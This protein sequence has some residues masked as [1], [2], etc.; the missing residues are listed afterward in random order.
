MIHTPKQN[1]LLVVGHGTRHAE[2][3]R[4]FWDVVAQID[5]RLGG[6]PVAAGFLEMAEPTISAAVEQLAAQGARH[7]IV[8]PLLLFAA[9]HA[10]EDIPRAAR[11]AAHRSSVTVTHAQPLEL[12]PELLAL[13]AS[14]FH[15]ALAHEQTAGHHHPHPQ[16]VAWILVGRGSR[17]PSATACFEQ[18]LRERQ[19][20]TPVG[21]ARG[22]FLAMAQPRL[23]AVVEEALNLPQKWVVIQPHLLFAGEL[24][25]HVT[26][27]VQQQNHRQ[28]RQRWC[29][30]PRLGCDARVAAALIDCYRQALECYRQAFGPCTDSGQLT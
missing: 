27:I 17:D 18:L 28:S 14:R 7:V 6:I 25:D 2:G 24:S 30:A 22:A 3:Q 12:H 5:H 1:A 11:A 15:E 4:E 9:G 10:R 8:A 13:S 16:D 23:E 19:Q 29:L 26:R 20:M 21:V